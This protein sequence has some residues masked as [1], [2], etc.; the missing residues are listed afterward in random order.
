MKSHLVG[1]FLGFFIIYYALTNTGKDSKA[2]FDMMSV[3]IVMGG[4][5]SVS[6]MTNGCGWYT[7]R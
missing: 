4:S 3:I 1:L 2:Y 7:P 6:L 5:L